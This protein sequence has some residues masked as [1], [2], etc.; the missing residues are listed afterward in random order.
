MWLLSGR[1]GPPPWTGCP[2]SHDSAGAV[3]L[4]SRE[5]TEPQVPLPGG[6]STP[7][8]H[9]FKVQCQ[10]HPSSEAPTALGPSDAS[11][12]PQDEPSLA[13]QPGG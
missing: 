11:G 10:V 9:L 6:R 13:A 5:G 4:C 12:C 3:S 8:V 7:R 2:S 1:R